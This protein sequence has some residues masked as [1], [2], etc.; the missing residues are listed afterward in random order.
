M[1][2]DLQ[3]RVVHQRHMDKLIRIRHIPTAEQAADIFAKSMNPIKN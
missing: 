1:L 3:W 2:L